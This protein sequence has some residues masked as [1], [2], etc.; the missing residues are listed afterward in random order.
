MHS[1]F[2]ELVFGG[3]NFSVATESSARYTYHSKSVRLH[4]RVKVV[5]CVSGDGMGSVRS[6]GECLASGCSGRWR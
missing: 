3:D 2:Y 6:G 4:G 5:S 1:G